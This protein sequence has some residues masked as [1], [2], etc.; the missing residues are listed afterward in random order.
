MS[1]K[2]N[3]LTTNYITGNV[4]SNKGMQVSYLVHG[5]KPEDKVTR[6]SAK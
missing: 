4:D 1:Q 6:L 3:L 2:A 5:F